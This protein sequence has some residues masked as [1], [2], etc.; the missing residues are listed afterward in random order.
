HSED[1]CRKQLVPIIR[2]GVTVTERGRRWRFFMVAGRGSAWRAASAALGF[3]SLAAG[4]RSAHAARPFALVPVQRR[5]IVVT[6]LA[7][8]VVQP[9]TLVEIKSKASGEI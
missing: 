1:A 8:G 3:A 4:C 6:A 9:D 7:S 5:N 2:S